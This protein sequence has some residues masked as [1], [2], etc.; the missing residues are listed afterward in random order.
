MLYHYVL[1]ASNLSRLEV[2]EDNIIVLS[3][4]I[5]W[6]GVWEWLKDKGKVSIE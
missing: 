1:L 3:N 5:V 6:C 2:Y 4:F